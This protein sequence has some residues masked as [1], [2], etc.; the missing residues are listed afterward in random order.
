MAVRGMPVHLARRVALGGSREC[1]HAFACGT[2]FQ[3][4]VAL[5]VPCFKGSSLPT[6]NM[7]S[8]SPSLQ[9]VHCALIPRARQDD[10][11]LSVACSMRSRGRTTW[12]SMS[13]IA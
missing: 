13:S 12:R 10:P 4:G 9:A 1:G 7:S 8:L 3:T 2:S 5:A 6:E 11:A